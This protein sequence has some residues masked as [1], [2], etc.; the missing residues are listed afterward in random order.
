MA[1]AALA[2]VG[3]VAVAAS[4][5]VALQACATETFD[6][7]IIDVAP[8]EAELVGLVEM[9][10]QRHHVARILVI[11][12]AGMSRE[13]IQVLQGGADDDMVHPFATEELN[14]RVRNLGRLGHRQGSLLLAAG[15]LAVDIQQGTARVRGRLVDLGAREFRLLVYLVRKRGELVTR[16]EIAGAIYPPETSLESNAIDSSICSLRKML[17]ASGSATAIVTRRGH[18]YVFA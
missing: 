17:C 12:A 2:S 8:R 16:A 7:V 14:W 11:T 4:P 15:D 9:L 1:A 6:V 18:G 3:R 13:R 10:W 5:S